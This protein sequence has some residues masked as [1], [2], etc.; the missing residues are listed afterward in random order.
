M[1]R[2]TCEHFTPHGIRCHACETGVEK[3]TVQAQMP[4]YICY[5]KVYALK[6]KQVTAP[7]DG[8]YL[9]PEDDRYAPIS[10]T[11]DYLNKH[12]VHPGG[13]YVVHEGGYCSFS[14]AFS[15]ESGYTLEP[16]NVVALQAENAALKTRVGELEGELD[17][18][19]FVC[20]DTP[21]ERVFPPQESLL[22]KATDPLPEGCYCKPGR[23]S[24]PKPSWCR[25]PVKR[26]AKQEPQE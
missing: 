1:N 17:A 6:I 26:T 7:D 4:R 13:Y 11:S 10:V 18:C 15:F 24:A 20:L 19:R 12:D 9:I 23:C 5:K 14:P 2:D 21:P 22:H 3:M 8:P 16:D 25:D